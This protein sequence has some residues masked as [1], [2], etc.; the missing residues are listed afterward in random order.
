MYCVTMQR[1]CCLG[2]RRCV[3][4]LI[5]LMRHA[6][7][8]EV[9]GTGGEKNQVFQMRRG[10][11]VERTTLG[12]IQSDP[13][14]KLVLMLRRNSLSLQVGF[15]YLVALVTKQK[16]KQVDAFQRIRSQA[17]GVFPVGARR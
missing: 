5:R 1:I 15:R 13:R 11:P 4:V 9:L 2:D 10:V 14:I 16:G 3:R 12:K 6:F 17:D 8:S 7:A